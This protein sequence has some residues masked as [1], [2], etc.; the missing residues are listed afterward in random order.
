MRRSEF[1]V[2]D[3]EAF[4]ALLAECEYGTLSLI[5]NGEPYGVP[6]NF[7]WYDGAICFHGAKEGRKAE[8]ICNNTKVSFSA[9][10]PYSLIPSY[11]S[12]TT[13]ACPATQFFAS[14]HIAGSVETVTNDAKKCEILTALMQKLQP[15]GGYEPIDAKNPIYAKMISQT[16]VFCI[17]PSLT[18]MKVKAG[19]H[20]SDE[21]KSMLIQKLKER[22][23]PLDNNT[24]K[25]IEVSSK[26][27]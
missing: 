5:D 23:S 10:K 25:V 2:Q 4:D 20:L 12:G 16:A 27:G 3:N 7:V 14:V 22:N 6:V 13:V 18:S 26:K 17:V 11:F 24:L 1:E 9:V 19:Q 21:R 15:N 8:A